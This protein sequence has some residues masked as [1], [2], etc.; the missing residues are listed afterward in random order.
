MTG[1]GFRRERV[2]NSDECVRNRRFAQ[3]SVDAECNKI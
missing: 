2:R 3:S 1:K